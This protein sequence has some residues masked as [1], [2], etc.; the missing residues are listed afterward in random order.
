MRRF[1]VQRH[2]ASRL[3][4]DFRLEVDGVLVSWAVPRGPSMR[5]LEKRRAARTEDH[6]LEYLA[7]E[8]V[9]PAGGYG[10]GDVIVWDC[11]TWE[12]ETRDEPGASIGGGELKFVLHGERLKGRFVI[13]RT[14][15][16][17]G[18]REDWLLIHKRDEHAVED[19]DIDTHRTSVI[20]GRSNDDVAT[21][22]PARTDVVAP[23]SIRDLD[24]D[25]ARKDP[26]PAF[27]KPMLATP[28]DRAFSDAGW[29]FELKLDGYRVQ[30]VVRDGA[31]RLWTRNRKDAAAYFPAFAAAPPEWIGAHD[32]IIDGEM[33]ALDGEGRPSFSLLQ[34]LS[35]MSGL[36]AKRGERR[37]GEGPP[38]SAAGTLVYHAFD[39]LHMD[40]WDLAA[41]PLEERK[42]LLRLILR[43]HP[44]VRYVTHVV[45]HG[46][47]FQAAVK[48][49]GPRRQHGQGQRKP[50][51]GR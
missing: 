24:L 46:E 23:R 44:S 6:P 28:V 37:S 42:R 5:P 47:D 18:G 9:I 20:S 11:G 30:A 2:R 29:L 36:G 41:V 14:K 22:G 50:V 1:V 31:L 34:D 3:H 25:G 16:E 19:W 43:E 10:A 33:V 8:G 26:M 40:G 12:P 7:F 17:R 15:Q 32:A 39:V 49:A 45:E 21:G 38:T 27:I 35:G 13:V 51:R 48:A 4:Y